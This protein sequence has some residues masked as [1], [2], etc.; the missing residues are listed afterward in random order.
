MIKT[1]LLAILSLLINQNLQ[2]QVRSARQEMLLYNYA[3]A[4]IL[5]D[6]AFQKGNAENRPEASQMLAE[7]YRRQSNPEKAKEWYGKAISLGNKDP[8]NWFY[9]ACCQR[10]CGDYM[11]AKMTFLKFDS[12]SPADIRGKLNAAFCDSALTWQKHKPAVEIWNALELNSRQSDIGTVF[13][14]DQ[15]LFASD[16]LDDKR[17]QTYGWTGNSYF[18]IYKS[19][20]IQ[21]DSGSI[22]FGY[23]EQGPPAFNQSYHDGPLCFNKAMDEVFINRTVELNDRGRR[24]TGLIRTHL[25]KIYHAEKKNGKWSKPEHFFLNSDSYSVG[26]PALSPD[27]NTLYF[28]SDKAGGCGGTDIWSCSR[29][30]NGWTEPV[31]LGKTINTAGNE[32][33]PFLADNGDLYF[34]SDGH[35]G[36][37][38]LDIFVAKKSKDSWDIPV[39]LGQPIN[40]SRDDFA[41]TLWPGGQVGTFSSNR[42]GGSGSDDIYCFRELPLAKETPLPVKAIAALKTVPESLAVGKTYTIKNIYYDFDKW[43]IRKDAEHSLDSLVKILREYSLTVE[44]R[45][46]TDCR[47]SAEYNLLLSQKRAESVVLYLIKHG[48]DPSRLTATGYGKSYLINHCNCGMDV[49]CTETEH[50]ANRRTEFRITGYI[51]IPAQ[52]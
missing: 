8:L 9:L 29:T 40:S 4:I 32:M 5:L 31:S 44:I 48:I 28:V 16:R 23:P 20:I 39:N 11:L 12:I 6:K 42:P 30:A 37:G 24:D 36:F 46:H 10:S 15:V 47:G 41:Y 49:I 27:G 43:N 52:P 22:K 3:H 19:A 7:C 25:L 18:R 38:G 45:A 35:P 2:C 1:V 17:E 34:A 13:C 21:A 51:N 26:H 33:F 14:G 50:Q